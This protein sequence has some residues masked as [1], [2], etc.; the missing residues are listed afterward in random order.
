MSRDQLQ[1]TP[2]DGIQI[3]MSNRKDWILIS[4]GAEARVWKIPYP[5]TLSGEMSKASLPSASRHL[6]AKERF[7]KRY[8]HPTLDAR[9]TK[10]RSRME[11]RILQKCAK[12][13]IPCPRVVDVR[14]T[15]ESA[16]QGSKE[17][18][19]LC[20]EWL[21]DYWTVR[22]Y[23]ED[24]VET[25]ASFSSSNDSMAPSV[26]VEDRFRRVA[27]E[28]GHLIAQLHS[29]GIVHGDLTTSN[30][31]LPRSGKG[32]SE[33]SSRKRKS[34]DPA[35]QLDGVKEPRQTSESITLI[36]FGLAK[37]TIS[38]EE[39]AVDLYVLERTL[40]STHPQVVGPHNGVEGKLDFLQCI[41]QAYSDSTTANNIEKDQHQQPRLT[42]KEAQAVLT[43]LEQV[44]L[45]GRKRECFG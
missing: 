8:R 11:R 38:A 34:P 17:D 43:R 2:D 45:R 29:I 37:N 18:S 42:P 40:L 30:M 23:L 4:Q 36:D 26:S 12:N 21:I 22:E 20:M 27:K 9:L 7:P 19:I 24:L 39:R 41:W 15:S 32:S 5:N 33:N 16:P 25:Q 35:M 13:H 1:S 6:I 44:R 10:Q 28:M 3:D 14:A 31:M